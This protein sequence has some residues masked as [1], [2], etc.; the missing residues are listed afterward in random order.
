VQQRHL[1]ASEWDSLANDPQFVRLLRSRRRFVVPCT[2]F[3]IAFYLALP[4]GITFARSF[5]DSPLGGGLTVAYAYGLLQFVMAW[6]LLAVYMQAA[7]RFDERARAI[8]ARLS[9][10]AAP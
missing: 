8:V 1:T 6:V 7:K 3:F 4:L 5:M 2:L 9:D 10:G